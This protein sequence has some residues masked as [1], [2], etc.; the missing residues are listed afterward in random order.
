MLAVIQHEQQLLVAKRVG[1]RRRQGAIDPLA[2]TQDARNSLRDESRVGER[3]EFDE[4]DT[5]LE[6]FKLPA[7][8]LVAEARL[9]HTARS[10]E[11]HQAARPE[12]SPDLSDLLFATDEARERKRE[13][14]E[15][16]LRDRMIGMRDR[17]RT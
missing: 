15:S 14:M 12:Q 16:P 17:Q 6:R 11:R 3:R 10:R 1:Q 5:G 13:I 7:S 4:P 2:N 9:P 8:K